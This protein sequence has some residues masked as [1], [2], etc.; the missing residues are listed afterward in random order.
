MYG[1]NHVFG[2]DLLAEFVILAKMSGYYEG[3]NSENT[4]S[5]NRKLPRKY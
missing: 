4:E 2:F 3:D 1:K 5:Y